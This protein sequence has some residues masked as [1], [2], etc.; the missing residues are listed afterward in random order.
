[1]TQE[2]RDQFQS[3]GFIILRNLFSNEEVV[4][5]REWLLSQDPAVL[6]KSWTETEPGVPLAVY[7]VIHELTNPLG[8]IASDE[9]IARIASDLMGVRTYIWASKVNLKAAWCGAAEYYH[10][11]FVYWKDRGYP[12]D[13]MLSCM[14]FMDS[15]SLSN[16]ALHVLPGTHHHGELDHEPFFNINGL[17]KWMI[18]PRDLQEYFET[19]GIEVVEGEPGDAVFFHA[20]LIHGSGHNIS[21]RNRMICLVQMNT[22]DNE[23]TNVEELSV[24]FNIRRATAELEEAER[25]L[26]FFNEKLL[27]QRL[28][29]DV[30]F[31]APIPREEQKH[32]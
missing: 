29:T 16:A 11:D 28:A 3:K 15:H 9:R 1:M 4:E 19:S 26:H 23:P 10:Q 27:R 14:V 5:A 8:R 31:G 20:S 22:F 6:R 25:R 21:P 24:S 12:S 17:S 30:T 32:H 13:Q 2:L 7:S 18:P